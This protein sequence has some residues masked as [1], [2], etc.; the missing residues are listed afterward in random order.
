MKQFVFGHDVG[1]FFV[2]PYVGAWIETS[3]LKGQSLFTFVAPYVGA[4]I[5]TTLEPSDTQM[6]AVAPYVGAW[7]ET[8]KSFTPWT[9]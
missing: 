5:E 3:I 8:T 2:A 6:C 4:W 9:N 7:I 1:V